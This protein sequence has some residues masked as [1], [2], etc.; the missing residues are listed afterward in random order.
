MFKKKIVTIEGGLGSQILGYMKYLYF[1][2]LS[3][4]L[5]F[6]D[7]TYFNKENQKNMA[8]NNPNLGV[9]KW[10][11]NYYGIKQQEFPTYNSKN[12][13][14]KKIIN[15]FKK[16]LTAPLH[17]YAVRK[18]YNNKFPI[19]DSTYQNIYTLIGDY[20]EKYAAVH[21]RA[22]DYLRVASLFYTA[23]QNLETLVSF[24]EI[25]PKKI[26]FLSDDKYT[27]SFK[28]NVTKKL[29]NDRNYIYMD[30][31]INQFYAHAIMRNANILFATNSTF[32][33]TSAL[34]QENEGISFMPTKFAGPDNVELNN[35]FNKLS[36]LLAL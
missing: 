17:Y 31:D 33:I 10:G 3:K 8:K 9:R 25:L 4:D 7:L 23:E 18:K 12:L 32:S 22:G 27:E 36:K 35:D 26:I 15:K 11:L 19:S 28:K 1:K 30:K 6:C 16:E 5:F 24:R 14:S 29:G 20:K 34:L 21:T 2:E 13:I